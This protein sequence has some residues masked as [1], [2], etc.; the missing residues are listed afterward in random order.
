MANMITKITATQIGTVD[1][2]TPLIASENTLEAGQIENAEV[3]RQNP[4]SKDSEKLP[5][6]QIILLC[7]ARITEPIAFFSIFPFIG[8]MIEGAAG[9][10]ES[11][12]GFY[13][14]LIVCIASKLKGI[15]SLA[16][17]VTGVYILFHSDAPHDSLGS[18]CGQVWKKTSSCGFHGW[19]VYC[20]CI[21]WNKP[22]HLA[23]DS[24]SIYCRGLFGNYCVSLNLTVSDSL[25]RLVSIYINIQIVLCVHQYQKIV[26]QRHKPEHSATL[27]F[28]TT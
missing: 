11:E 3:D 5:V 4:D 8:Q 9:V 22:H 6:V 18:G 17:D 7:F 24:V 28:Q 1:E 12:V 23:D 13:S 10:D 27:H 26:H 19:A 15:F 21:I 16:D 2:T 20:K 25:P 14:G